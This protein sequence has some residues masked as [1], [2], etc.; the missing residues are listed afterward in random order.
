MTGLFRIDVVIGGDSQLSKDEIIKQAKQLANDKQESSSNKDDNGNYIMDFYIDLL[1]TR[2][3]DNYKIFSDVATNNNNI[4]DS[5][6]T[7]DGVKISG[8]IA[9][10]NNKVVVV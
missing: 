5:Y 1:D 10:T 4:Q 2:T 6:I 8:V 7:T 3:S 9:M